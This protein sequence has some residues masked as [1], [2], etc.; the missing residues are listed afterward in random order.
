E[1]RLDRR[2]TLQILR[3]LV[4]NALRYTAGRVSL[5]IEVGEDAVLRASVSDEGEGFSAT[6][7]EHLFEPFFR[8]R[9][10]QGLPGTGLGLAIVREC[11]R[12]MGGEIR[13]EAV[14]PIGSRFVLEFTEY[15]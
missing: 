5:R 8:G 11:A 15:A 4:H 13:Y 6:E 12:I 9:A 1:L 3:N 10:S 2:L 14:E 7:Q